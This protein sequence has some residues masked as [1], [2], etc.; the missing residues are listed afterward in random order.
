MCNTN[1][2]ISLNTESFARKKFPSYIK[3]V[4]KLMTEHF[5]LLFLIYFDIKKMQVIR[6]ILLND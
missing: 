6:E 1:E 4:K 5:S 3:L 2:P